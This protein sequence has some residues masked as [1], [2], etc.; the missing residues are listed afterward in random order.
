MGAGHVYEHEPWAIVRLRGHQSGVRECRLD[1]LALF[2]SC[3]VGGQE[4]DDRANHRRT[5]E[6]GLELADLGR[7]DEAVHPTRSDLAVA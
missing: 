5:K 6:R 4:I 3:R 2:R 7:D 1:A